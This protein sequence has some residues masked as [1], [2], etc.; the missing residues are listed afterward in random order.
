MLL[1]SNRNLK[2]LTLL[3][4]FLPFTAHPGTGLPQYW[5]CHDLDEYFFICA[6]T[7]ARNSRAE[8]AR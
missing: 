6:T 5:R 7:A 8:S 4:A 1:L 3:V 2:Y